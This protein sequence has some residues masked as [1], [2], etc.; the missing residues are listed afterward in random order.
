MIKALDF[1]KKG[2]EEDITILYG[3]GKEIQVKKKFLEPTELFETGVY[4]S[5]TDTNTNPKTDENK[6]DAVGAVVDR[7]SER[8][9]EITHS[10]EEMRLFVKDNSSL[11]HDS[12]DKCID[13]IG[14]YLK[15]LEDEVKNGASAIVN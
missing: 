11:S 6:P 8:L 14:S 10:L 2:D 1:T 3:G 4:N 12:L 7:L 9:K 13:E 5:E 15:S